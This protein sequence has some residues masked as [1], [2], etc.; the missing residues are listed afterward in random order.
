VIPVSEGQIKEEIAKTIAANILQKYKP[1]F[2]FD[3]YDVTAQ[4]LAYIKKVG[5][6]LPDEVERI[7]KQQMES[8]KML[9]RE[10]AFDEQRLRG[11]IEYWK[12]KSYRLGG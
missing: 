1:V 6:L 5:C 4:I 8:E 11:E 2:P 3:C 12:I 10:A 7:E 9:N